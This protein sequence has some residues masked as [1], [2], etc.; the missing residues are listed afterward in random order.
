MGVIYKLKREVIEYILQSKRDNLFLSCRELAQL[1]GEKF[2]F[3]VSKSS[4][5]AVIRDARLSSPIGRRRMINVQSKKFEIPQDKKRQLYEHT[6]SLIS[7]DKILFKKEEP[8]K[9]PI[10]QRLINAPTVKGAGLIFLKAAQWEISAKSVLGDLFRKYMDNQVPD[11]FD[12]ICDALTCLKILPSEILDDITQEHHGFWMLNGFLQK[13]EAAKLYDWAKHAENFNNLSFE[14]LFRLEQV[15]LDVLGFKVALED[16][17]QIIIDARMT[18]VWTDKVHPDFWNS[19]NKALTM[20]SNY[21]ISNIH[22]LV[23][24]CCP[25]KRN[26]FRPIF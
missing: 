2:R 14:Y 4:I 8:N 6:Q 19:S 25:R 13:P 20:L 15:F 16:G 3:R 22:P 26:F 23:F 1:T 10:K 21:L 11:N 24:F 18:T 5:N 7:Q 9:I 12:A 17:K